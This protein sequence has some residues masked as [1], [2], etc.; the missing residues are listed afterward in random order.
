MTI[1]VSIDA[2]GGDKGIPVTVNAGI[3]A[4]GLFLDLH[5]IF[6]GD[7]ESISLELEK[8]S[9]DQS[10]KSRISIVHASEI[11]HMHES[12]S[13]ALRKK[14]DSSMRVAINLVN[15]NKADA[16]ISAGNTGA[17]MAISR[18]VL[19]TIKGVDRPAIMGRMPTTTGHTHMLD[20]GANID[21]SPQSLLEF[22]ILGSIAVQYTENISRPTV[23]LLNI[24][25]EEIKGNENIKKTSELLKESNLNYVGFIEGNDIY[26]GKVDL[27][28][29]N[30]FEGN[31]ALKASEGVAKLMSHYLK[32][33][34][35]KNWITR[36]VAIIA[37]PVLKDFKSSLNPGLYNGA[38]F[39]GLKGIVIKSHGGA[40]AFSFL[41]AI[42]EAYLE[43]QVN[44]TDKISDKVS[45][46]LQKDQLN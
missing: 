28:V 6:V 35:N 12:P 46:E 44:I 11:V 23:G 21:S 14:K 34:F 45:E 7:K 4:L 8:F 10:V 9:F 24:G 5:V 42:R 2:S 17:L 22:A 25:E 43:S 39:L 33:S 37:Y 38:S 1:R 15:E 32:K 40:D 31:I 3:Q 19:K 16:C 26:E 20:L 18:F 36:I 30:G 41:Q 29:C 13:S 27:V